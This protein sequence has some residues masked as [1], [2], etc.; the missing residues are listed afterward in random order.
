[1]NL[2]PSTN[3]SRTTTITT[4]NTTITSNNHEHEEDILKTQ[5]SNTGPR[6]QNNNGI[7][8]KEETKILFYFF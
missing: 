8:K 4:T 5:R 6:F 3:K 1:M 7:Q 2:L